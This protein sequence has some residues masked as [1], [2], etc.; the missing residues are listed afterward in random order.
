MAKPRRHRSSRR[1]GGV[2]KSVRRDISKVGSTGTNIAE[3]G[4]SGIY[5]FF[6]K[7]FSMGKKD[8]SGVLSTRKRRVKHRRGSKRRH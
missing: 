8:I 4:V 1:R 3:K 6:S 7:G 2:V 5:D